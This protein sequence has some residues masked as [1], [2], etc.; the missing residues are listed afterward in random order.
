M[1]SFESH[2]KAK[3]MPKYRYKAYTNS[4]EFR[5]GKIVASS[6]SEAIDLVNLQGLNSF[7]AELITTQSELKW[8]QKEVF[9]TKNIS[10]QELA[11]FTREFST[12]AAADLPLDKLLSI[13]AEHAPS[14]K[15]SSLISAIYDNVMD[16]RAL[17]DAMSEQAG[18]FPNFYVSMIRAGEGAGDLKLVF[19]D[20]SQFLERSLDIRARIQSALIYPL[21]LM[22]VAL[23]AIVLIVNLLIPN[24]VPLFEDSGLEIPSSVAAIL[25]MRSIVIDYWMVVVGLIA[26]TFFLGSKAFVKPVFRERIDAFVLRLPIAGTIITKSETARFSRILATLLRSGVTLLEAMQIAANVA[27]N[28]K[29]SSTLINLSERIREGEGLSASLRDSSIFP[30]LAERLIAVGEEVG[31]LEHVLFHVA[32]IFEVQVQREIERL[33]TLLTPALTVLIGLGIGTL[34]MSVMNAIL[35]VNE[36]ALQ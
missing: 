6:E 12:L 5:E 26:I 32:Q 7:S 8:W 19:D 22:V 34:I 3:L 4:G 1:K 16:G 35:S 10:K 20:L 18:V 27:Q 25:T 2:A 11:L 30:S 28:R 15:L 17:S 36:L 31:K 33:M 9:S 24:I 13:M 21:V 23:V 14:A 29:F